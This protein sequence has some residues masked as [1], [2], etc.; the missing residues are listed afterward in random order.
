MHHS[1]HD[2]Y[3][4]IVQYVTCAVSVLGMTLR[5]LW[6][7]LVRSLASLCHASW[8]DQRRHGWLLFGESSLSAGAR[9][10]LLV[11]ALSTKTQWPSR[12]L[13]SSPG[14][15]AP[16]DSPAHRRKQEHT[17]HITNMYNSLFA[18]LVDM[19][20]LIESKACFMCMCMR[21]YTINA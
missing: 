10:S 7:C 3:C 2:M 18:A 20:F 15:F 17:C 16:S 11:A 12:V 4:I 21:R 6:S 1:M 14:C 19:C 13:I 8:A 5:S 9:I